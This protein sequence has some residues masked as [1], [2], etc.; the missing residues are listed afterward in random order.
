MR[1]ICRGIIY[2]RT[3][4]DGVGGLQRKQRDKLGIAAE[5][6]HHHRPVGLREGLVNRK[7]K[8]MSIGRPEKG[9]CSCSQAILQG[10]HEAGEH[11][12]LDQLPPLTPPPPHLLLW[13]SIQWLNLA[14]SQRSGVYRFSP[15]SQLLG[16]SRAEAENRLPR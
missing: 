2:S 4:N 16:C 1:I 9:R 12:D 13:L 15:T 6:G 5:K 14:G 10:R 11:K 7:E 8:V 3:T